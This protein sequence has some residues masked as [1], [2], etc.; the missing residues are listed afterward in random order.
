LF[1]R[2]IQYASAS[3]KLVAISLEFEHTC[4]RRLTRSRSAQ[5]HLSAHAT[6]ENVHSDT[7]Q[8]ARVTAKEVARF[9]NFTNDTAAKTGKSAGSDRL[10]A[11]RGKR[12]GTDLDLIAGIPWLAKMPHPERQAIISRAATGKGSGA[13]PDDRHRHRQAGAE[14]AYNHQGE[15]GKQ[16]C[17][18]ALVVYRHV[19]LLHR[20]AKSKS[21]HPH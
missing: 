12:Q 9:A 8:D 18:W 16:I 6:Y 19:R 1:L 7:K 13:N 10:D 11:T 3:E 5:G 17:L 20:T 14:G 2:S 15:C 4:Y 21:R